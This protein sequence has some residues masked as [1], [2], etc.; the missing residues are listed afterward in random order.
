MAGTDVARAQV[1]VKVAAS[2][3]GHSPVRGGSGVRKVSVLG[4]TG[5]VGVS[6]LDLIGR[7]PSMFEIVAL[8][9][10]GNAAKLAEFALRHRA[11]LAVVAD[12]RA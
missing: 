7:N 3:P 10:N 11:E 4:A 8:T 5:S 12:E 6:T 1:N 2:G 9:A